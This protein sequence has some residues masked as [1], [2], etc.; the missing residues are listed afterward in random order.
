M[1][2]TRNRDSTAS[3]STSAAP[4]CKLSITAFAGD[5]ASLARTHDYAEAVLTHPD[6][7][8]PPSRKPPETPRSRPGRLNNKLRPTVIVH[9][10]ALAGRTC[11]CSFRFSHAL[12]GEGVTVWLF[13][14]PSRGP[15]AGG[16]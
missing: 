12:P 6:T 2:S 7:L 9:A 3:N 10:L 15:V 11:A 13:C 5:H 1:E 8:G 16:R 4:S 14:A